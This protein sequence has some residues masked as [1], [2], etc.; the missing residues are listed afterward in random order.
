MV[1]FAYRHKAR[2]FA[3]V[4][5]RPNETGQIRHKARKFAQ[6][7]GPRAGRTSRV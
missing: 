6:V 2:K 1:G 3:Q 5:N 7:P 4:P